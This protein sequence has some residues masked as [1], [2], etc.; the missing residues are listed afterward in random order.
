VILLENESRRSR[1][2][3]GDII[4]TAL[5]L[6]LPVMFSNAFETIYN[7]TDAFWLGKVG[8]EAVAAPSVS[9]P[10]IFLLMIMT[11][12]FGISGLTLVSQ[13]IGADEPEKANQVAGQLLL[14]LITASVIVAIFGFF[15]AELILR[16]LNIP[17]GVLLVAV[18]YL[19]IT[20]L[21]IPFM[22]IHFGFQS[23]L[24]GY[25]DTRTPM[26]LSIMSAILDTILDP[27]FIFGW[28][29]LPEMGAAGAA[30]TTVMTRALAGGIGIYLLFSG[31]VGIKVR[32][33]NLKPDWG[34]IK[35]IA[36]IGVPFSIGQSGSALGFN[37][38]TALIAT[39]DKVLGGT[40]LLLSAYGIGNRISSFLQIVIF[41]GVSAVSTMIGQNL[42][43]NQMLRAN[44]VVKKLF[45]TFIGISIFQSIIVYFLRIPL[46]RFFI[47]NQEVIR[48]G[49]TYITFFIPFFPFFTLFRLCMS[50]FEASGKTRVSMVLSLIRFWGMRILFAYI[51]YFIL[52]MGSVGI[53]IGLALGNVLSAVLSLIWLSRGDWRQKII[54]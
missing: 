23:L 43:A 15:N 14:I 17:E 26:I 44:E 46:Y 34:L 30:L 35:R 28:F 9:W 1:I 7:L 41:G 3:E 49:S 12:G 25:G 22:M 11:G 8:P 50:V 10:I 52:E 54:D 5:T 47:N 13:Y 53:W 24:R 51:F 45:F 32:I 37:V 4:P 27:F 48:L 16:L 29:G 21:G 20:F 40:G 19:R 39:E 2:L 31:R 38:L 42:G 36:K 6:A 33:S 18:S